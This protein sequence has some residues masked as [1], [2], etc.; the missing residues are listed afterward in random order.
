MD[1]AFSVGAVEFVSPRYGGMYVV[2][3]ERCFLI[4][5]YRPLF[6][7]IG[8][9]AY[10]ATEKGAAASTNAKMQAATVRVQSFSYITKIGS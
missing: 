3:S 5:R 10:K 8:L 9:D 4:L 2:A 1:V 7:S 6:L